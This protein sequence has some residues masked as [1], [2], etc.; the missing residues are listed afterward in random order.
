M[1]QN[2]LI[3]LKF[4][5]FLPEI[6]S[7]QS[8]PSC[9][10]MKK[11]IHGQ[12]KMKLLRTKLSL[13]AI[14]TFVNIA[15]GD[16]A[17]ATENS[18]ETFKNFTKEI[19]DCYTKNAKGDTPTNDVSNKC[20]L[21]YLPNQVG[22]EY[23]SDKSASVS[24]LSIISGT[25]DDYAADRTDVNMVRIEDGDVEYEVGIGYRIT[26]AKYSLSGQ[27]SGSLY[28]IG[29]TDSPVNNSR[30]LLTY[31]WIG[32]VDMTKDSA[33]TPNVYQNLPLTTDIN[34]ASFASVLN[35]L[36]SSLQRAT[37]Q[38]TD[39]SK[40]VN[41]V[42][43]PQILNARMRNT[44]PAMRKLLNQNDLK[45]KL[46]AIGKEFPNGFN[47]KCKS[48]LPNAHVIFKENVPD[49]KDTFGASLPAVFSATKSSSKAQVLFEYARRK[50]FWLFDSSDRFFEIW[51]SGQ[52]ESA[53]IS[54]LSSAV[55]S[56]KANKNNVRV[57]YI[58]HSGGTDS[59]ASIPAIADPTVGVETALQAIF[60]LFVDKK[61][62]I[63]SLFHRIRK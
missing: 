36:S 40:A 34:A 3:S 8:R 20:I 51:I 59:S 5:S 12:A 27:I 46:E 49:D 32:L 39:S 26:A 58:E 56:I 19:D 14:F 17:I 11:P 41:Y 10:T 48:M 33:D 6:M 44:D 9:D 60:K 16:N 4:A 21:G 38:A 52:D 63:G 18:P 53:S 25:R 47:Q 55:F 50:N 30:Y 2:H 7:Q 54:S 24:F 45:S 43:C 1:P 31:D 15:F 37:R 13:I 62:A 42:I 28:G 22:H 57:A 23:D 29:L 35:T 61:N